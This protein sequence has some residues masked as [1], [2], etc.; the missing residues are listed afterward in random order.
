ML[1]TMARQAQMNARCSIREH[2]FGSLVAGYRLSFLVATGIALLAAVL[3]ASRLG[4]RD[5]QQ[6]LARQPGPGVPTA[7]G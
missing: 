7:T 5:C 3:A 4:S 2:A 6:E 1:D